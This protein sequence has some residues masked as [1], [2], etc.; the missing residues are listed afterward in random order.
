[1]TVNA[2]TDADEDDDSA[3]I[4]HSVSGYGTVTTAPD[5][6]VTVLETDPIAV[7]ASFGMAARTLLMKATTRPRRTLS[8][9][10]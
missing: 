3:T 4:T 8:K 10:R 5:V 6:A 2:A 7:T 1:M 9:M